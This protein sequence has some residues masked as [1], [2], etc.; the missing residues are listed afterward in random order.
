[1][2]PQRYTNSHLKGQRQTTFLADYSQ[3][4]PSVSGDNLYDIH[5]TAWEL[6]MGISK[7]VA[8]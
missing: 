4:D 2:T 6:Q 7:I 8:E 3:R 5:T 1:M